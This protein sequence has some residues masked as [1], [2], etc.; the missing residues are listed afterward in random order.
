MNRAEFDSTPAIE[1]LRLMVQNF[2]SVNETFNTRFS[3]LEL[4]AIHRAWMLSEWDIFPDNWTPR[5]IKEALKGLP[6]QWDNDEKP[7]Y[8]RM[9]KPEVRE[10]NKETD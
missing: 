6:P 3:M 5:Q 2:N 1:H 8:V 7:N 9:P 4:L 10:T